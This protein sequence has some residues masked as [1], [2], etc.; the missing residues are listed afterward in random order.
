MDLFVKIYL[1]LS[2][3][4]KLLDLVVDHLLPLL[5]SV[6]NL[7]NLIFNFLDLHF[8]IFNHLISI[9]DLGM[10]VIGKLILLSLLKVLLKQL[11]PCHQK[12]SLFISN[13]R[14]RSKKILDLFD[15]FFSLFP[16][17]TDVGNVDLKFGRP[18]SMNIMQL[19]LKLR[20][21]SLNVLELS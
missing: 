8:G 19:C 5:K 21:L 1:L 16:I 14:H 3:Y 18:F 4:V 2:N 9:L 10:Q 17:S 6:V 12:L 7:F 11:L 13:G 20:S 15:I